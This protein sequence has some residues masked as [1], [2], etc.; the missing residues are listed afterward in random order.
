VSIDSTNQLKLKPNKTQQLTIERARCGCW[1][2]TEGGKGAKE[3]C[4][5]SAVVFLNHS[6]PFLTGT[7][8]QCN[9]QY[10]G[11][12]NFGFTLQGKEASHQNKH[13]VF[14]I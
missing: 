7:N 3:W 12:Q 14:H 1:W 5:Q 11:L 9:F 4:I 6:K 13:F 2:E 10:K 8:L